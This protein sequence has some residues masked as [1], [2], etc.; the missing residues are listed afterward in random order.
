MKFLL[1]LLT[2]ALS[3]PAFAQIVDIESTT[4]GFLPPRMTEAQRDAIDDATAGTIIYNTD[5]K[6]LDRFDGT[7]WQNI[8]PFSRENNCNDSYDNDGD[9]LVDCHDPDCDFCCNTITYYSTAS[10]SC[11][12]V[13]CN[14]IDSSIRIFINDCDDLDACTYDYCVPIR[15]NTTYILECMHVSIDCDDDNPCTIDDCDSKLGCTHTP[16]ICDDNDPCTLDFCDPVKGCIKAIVPIYCGNPV[17]GSTVGETK[18]M[19]SYACNTSINAN[20]PEVAFHYATTSQQG[21]TVNVILEIFG[22]KALDLFVL[23][24]T[25]GNP[26]EASTCKSWGDS[27]VSFQASS[28]TDYWIIVDGLKVDDEADFR[29]SLSCS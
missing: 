10:D 27:S 14:P 4:Q 21:V 26:C 16:V 7:F 17:L 12:W 18:E 29:L 19:N 22:P 6:T 23:E 2:F 24:S 9:G 28:G 20:G 15:D 11:S 1:F 25:P 5:T 3:I 13:I 8:F